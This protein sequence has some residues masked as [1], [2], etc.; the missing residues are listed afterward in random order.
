MNQ[1]EKNLAKILLIY[2][3]LYMTKNRNS[4]VNKTLKA[5]KRSLNVIRNSE[6]DMFEKVRKEQI[7]VYEQAW[8][9]TF[10]DNGKTLSLGTFIQIIYESCDKKITNKWI[11]QKL[12][13]KTID[14]YFFAKTIEGKEYEIENTARNLAEEVLKL[15][16]EPIENKLKT[17][18]TILAQNKIVTEGYNYGKKRIN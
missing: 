7:C 11:G 1:R 8:N 5:L 13:E 2:N 6:S 16:G 3:Y 12:M 14:S 9:N 10:G 4:I 18:F 15:L 17:K